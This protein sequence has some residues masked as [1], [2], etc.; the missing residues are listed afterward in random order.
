MKYIKK[1][2][3]IYIWNIL[4][5]IN[6][7]FLYTYSLIEDCARCQDCGR[8]VHDYHVPNKFWLKVTESENGVWCYDCFCNRADKI[9]GVIKDGILIKNPMIVK[10]KWR[11]RIDEEKKGGRIRRSIERC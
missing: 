2:L 8:N 6:K 9:F 1:C 4:Q 3:H 11:M 5:W 10:F 7:R